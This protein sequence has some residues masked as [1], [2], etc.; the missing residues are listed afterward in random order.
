MTIS[1]R[2]RCV[3]PILL[4]ALSWFSSTP[5]F[6]Q[7]YPQKQIFMVVPAP[8][9][10]GTDYLARLIAQGLTQRLGQTVIVQNLSG[11]NGNIG[12]SHVARERPDGYTILMSYVGTQAINPSLYRSLNYSPAKDLT[13]VAMV[14]SYPFVIAVNPTVPAK[15]LGDLVALAKAQPGKLNFGS[16]GIGSGGHLV[17]EMFSKQNA[18]ALNHIPYAGSAPVM[19]DLLGGR[20]Q[21]I[22]DTLNTAGSYILA[23]KLRALAV[24]SRQRLPGY[25]DIPTAAEAGFPAMTVSGWYGVF[26]PAGTPDAIVKKLNEQIGEIVKTDDY[27]K[28]TAAL[29]YESFDFKTPEQFKGFVDAETK[30]WADVV[31]ASGAHVD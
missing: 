13:P 22:F 16:A 3:L 5:S 18:V 20:L 9:G 19:T 15:S 17:G 29:G 2:M 21:L 26:A 10:G 14:G 31:K 4:A 24:T 7:T 27:K 30:K 11:A 23:G 6:A 8:P 28:R 12:A 25:P 1:A